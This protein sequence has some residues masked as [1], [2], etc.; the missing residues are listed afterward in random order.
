MTIDREAVEADARLDGKWVLRTNTDLAP[1]DVAVTYKS[2]WRVE[3]V[4][5]EE[6]STLEVRPFFHH[7]DENR[8]GHGV[9]SFLALRLEVD[10]QRRLDERGVDI[11]WP[12]LMAD[13]SQVQAIHLS[14]E[15]KA[16]KIRTDLEGHAYAALE[17]AGIRPPQRLMPLGGGGH[18]VPYADPMLASH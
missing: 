3:R 11:S 4:F 14:L 10:L 7:C 1:E 6:K 17:A 2:L 8:I 13:L 5:R 16:W 9:A 12:D 18:V 15:G